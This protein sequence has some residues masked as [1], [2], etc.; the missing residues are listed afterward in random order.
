MTPSGQER[1][2]RVDRTPLDRASFYIEQLKYGPGA[3]KVE[4]VSADQMISQL[5]VLLRDARV[6]SMTGYQ[7]ERAALYYGRSLATSLQMPEI[8]AGSCWLDGL[9][10]GI[11]F[12]AGLRAEPRRPRR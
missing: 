10:H 3:G 9:M 5:E 8:L 2:P 12:A 7:L 4:G 11:A 1:D 6:D